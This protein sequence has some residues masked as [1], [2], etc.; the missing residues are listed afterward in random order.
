MQNSSPGNTKKIDE[1]QRLQHSPI[2]PRTR[3]ET[4]ILHIIVDYVHFAN[5][6]T[7]GLIPF[8]LFECSL[9]SFS[10]LNNPDID[11]QPLAGTF[12]MD[13]QQTW[14]PGSS[15]HTNPHLTPSLHPVSLLIYKGTPKRVLERLYLSKVTS[16]ADL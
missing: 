5:I 10:V 14:E 4:L 6:T 16:Q 15:D 7:F 3:M 8:L 9:W 2:I 13:K 1:W 11:F 12:C